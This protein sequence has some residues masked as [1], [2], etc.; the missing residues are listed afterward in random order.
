ML[1]RVL[2][3]LLVWMYMAIGL[4]VSLKVRE[5]GRR[6]VGEPVHA[7]RRAVRARIGWTVFLV[8]LGVVVASGYPSE[9]PAG[10]P[11][12][13]SLWITLMLCALLLWNLPDPNEAVCGRAGVRFGWS[14]RSYGDVESWRLTG[15]HLRCFW[16]N[17]WYAMVVPADQH[18]ELRAV[19]ER[20]AQGAES[21]FT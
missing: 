9:P 15:S 3:F 18:A 12:P 5:R 2:G 19:L 14:T 6:V 8:L 13:A 10:L 16:E 1:K 4:F 20:E 7:V 17:K 21:E 11:T